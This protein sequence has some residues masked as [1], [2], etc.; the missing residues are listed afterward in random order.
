MH[1]GSDDKSDEIIRTDKPDVEPEAGEGQSVSAK[2]PGQGK[3]RRFKSRDE[4][5]RYMGVQ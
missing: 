4:Y 5:E 2:E 1:E 3:G